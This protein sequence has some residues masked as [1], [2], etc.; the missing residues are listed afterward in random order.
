KADTDGDGTNDGEETILGRDPLK[1]GPDDKRDLG[2][3]PIATADTTSGTKTDTDATSAKLFQEYV[4][5]KTAK[6]T[7]GTEDQAAL[8]EAISEE[9][10][11]TILAKQYSEEDISIAGNNTTSLK[12]YGNK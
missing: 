3:N 1:K 5:L 10:I 7:V 6:G 12:T 4:R 2:T 8:A 9:G 11:P